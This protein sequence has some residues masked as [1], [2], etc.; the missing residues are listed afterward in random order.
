MSSAIIAQR[1]RNGRASYRPARETIV[2]H[3]YDVATLPEGSAKAFILD[4]H[5]SRS[6]PAA[7]HRFGLYWRGHLVGVAVFSQPVQDRVLTRVFPTGSALDSVELGRFVLLDQVPAN[8][9]TWFLARCRESLRRENLVGVVSFSDPIP[10]RTVEGEVVFPG[11]LGGIYQASS[12]RYLG[13]GTARTLRLLPDGSVLSARAIQKVRSGEQ[14]WRYVVA[15]LTRFGAPAPR[16][17]VPGANADVEELRSWLT[18]TT[19]LV[20]RPLRHPGNHRYAWPLNRHG[21][22]M[23]E[24]LPAVPYPKRTASAPVM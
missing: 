7:R 1:W 5:Y 11:H 16:C 13:R 4:H 21:L 9:E 19:S 18:S 24:R 2:P 10:R 14:G 8:G 15:Q 3:E 12:S 20:T 22:R 17:L 6:Y 23:L